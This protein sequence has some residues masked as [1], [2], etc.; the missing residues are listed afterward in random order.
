MKQIIISEEDNKCLRECLKTIENIL[1][2]GGLNLGGGASDRKTIKKKPTQKERVKNYD[3]I[4]S[5]GK[6]N[7]KPRHLRK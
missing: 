3:E 5:L 4:L 1:S 7:S 2:G 6:K